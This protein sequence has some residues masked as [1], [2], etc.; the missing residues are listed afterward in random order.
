MT[1]AYVSSNIALPC[2]KNKTEKPEKTE[3]QTEKEKCT[4]EKKSSAR[5]LSGKAQRRTPVVA[6]CADGPEGERKER[7]RDKVTRR[8]K[9]QRAFAAV[10]RAHTHPSLPPAHLDPL[11]HTSGAYAIQGVFRPATQLHS[12]RQ[13]VR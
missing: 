6:E 9:D 11:L 13:I 5:K 3:K 2:Q 4:Q 1:K 10:V 7:Q 8:T 12:A